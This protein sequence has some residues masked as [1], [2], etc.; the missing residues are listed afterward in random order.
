MLVMPLPLLS[1]HGLP[2]FIPSLRPEATHGHS[3]DAWVPTYVPICV[4]RALPR[5][6]S[7]YVQCNSYPHGS[8]PSCDLY[9]GV[10]LR[11][12]LRTSH[13][14]WTMPCPREFRGLPCRV[15]P[16]PSKRWM[17]RRK[18]SSLWAPN[19]PERN[20]SLHPP[21]V[22]PFASMTLNCLHDQPPSE[23]AVCAASVAL[24][25][26]ISVLIARPGD[27]EVPIH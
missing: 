16:E 20:R 7:H 14:L 24:L 10:C 3:F 21:T 1:P 23:V 2:A 19:G 15:T 4:G 18:G 25:P 11:K 9:G 17:L 27:V 5:N 26:P 22:R 8:P 6:T 12:S 13:H